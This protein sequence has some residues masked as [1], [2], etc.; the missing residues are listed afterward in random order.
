MGAGL[1]V[2]GSAPLGELGQQGAPRIGVLVT[3]TVCSSSNSFPAR[4]I[5][6]AARSAKP[7]SVNSR[8]ATGSSRRGYP[9]KRWRAGELVNNKVGSKVVGGPQRPNKDRETGHPLP[10]CQ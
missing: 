7:S 2:L 5:S 3:E 8:E 4:S 10:A 6:V 9:S 1:S